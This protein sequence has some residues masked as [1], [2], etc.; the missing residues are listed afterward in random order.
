MIGAATT[1]FL[2]L[3]DAARAVA[4]LGQSEVGVDPGEAET[5][6]LVTS[7]TE[8]RRAVIGLLALAFVLGVLGIV[9]WYKTGQLAR[10]RFARGYAGRHGAAAGSGE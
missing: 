4:Q 2:V 3:F 6:Q 7:S 1:L 9:Y 10:E 8:V 5:L